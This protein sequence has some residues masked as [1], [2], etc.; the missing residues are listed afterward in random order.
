[1]VELCKK[2]NNG[3]FML[4]KS[5]I[6]LDKKYAI[7]YQKSVGFFLKE[8]SKEQAILSQHNIVSEVKH[9]FDNF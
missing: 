4:I 5:K 8:C 7:L 9:K 1:M 3:M 2:V 6:K